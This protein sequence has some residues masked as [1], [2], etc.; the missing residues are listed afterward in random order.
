[1]SSSSATIVQ[2]SSNLRNDWEFTPRVAPKPRE[3]ASC[4]GVGA[5]QSRK[6]QAGPHP[7]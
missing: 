7:R 2:N 5:E 4:E 6:M 1:L 3:F